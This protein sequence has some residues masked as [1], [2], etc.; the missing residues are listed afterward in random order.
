MEGEL[1]SRQMRGL[2]D[3]ENSGLV[4][5]LDQDKYE[6]LARMYAL[7]RRVEGGLDLMRQVGGGER[8]VCVGGKAEGQGPWRSMSGGRP[9][10]GGQGSNVECCPGVG[11]CWQT[12]AVRLLMCLAIR[13]CSA[14]S[15]V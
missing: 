2:A 10:S 11:V 12:C 8:H 6:D 5:L 15:T 13:P 9:V 7:F 1:I 3:M 4:P 14:G